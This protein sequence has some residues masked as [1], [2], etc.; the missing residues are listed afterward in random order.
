MKYMRCGT[1]FS[2]LVFL[3]CMITCFLITPCFA[4]PFMP[5]NGPLPYIGALKTGSMSGPGVYY[6]SVLTK[7]QGNYSDTLKSN[8]RSYGI[9]NI[10]PSLLFR[11]PGPSRSLFLVKG[12]VV[13]LPSPHKTVQLTRFVSP[14]KPKVNSSPENGQSVIEANN[15]FAINL[16]RYLRNDPE[17][18]E[19]NL[20]FSPLSISSA[21]AITYEGA[22]GTTAE[23]IQEV[24]HFPVDNATRREGF[25]DVN[26][27]INSGNSGYSLKTANALWAEKTFPFLPEYTRIASQYYGATIKN[28][29]FI[30][31]PDQS[32]ATINRWVADQTNDKIQNI[33]PAGSI[34]PLTRLVI[35]NAIYFKGTWALQFDKSLTHDE[36]FTIA[37]GN[38]VNVPMMQ[39]TGEQSRFKYAETGTFQ[40]IEMPYS[41][42]N[43]KKLSMLVILPK[44]NNLAS[45]EGSLTA[46]TLSD[47]VHSMSEEQVPVYFPRFRLTTEY[48]LKNTLGSMGMPTAFS[49]SADLSGMDGK[50][51]LYISDVIHKAYVDVNEEGTEAAAATAVT[52]NTLAI[53]I[54]AKEFRADHPFVFFIM[55]DDTGDILFMGH[56]INPDS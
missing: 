8:D 1:T 7:V 27:G 3:T 43:G 36:T 56:V 41:H 14:G 40:A 44:E 50:R 18:Q 46:G 35:T 12:A 4:G 52:V 25:Q 19:Q 5:D 28:L 49:R 32:R 42:K 51:D 16:F 9:R 45:V 33:L 2:G 48:D 15:Q 53:E 31:Q 37:P 34:T 30:S 17:N 47:L 39:I 21:L 26:V 29:N 55:D 10:T 22:R 23:E 38:T 11:T 20:F 54:P 13:T 6:E 24:F